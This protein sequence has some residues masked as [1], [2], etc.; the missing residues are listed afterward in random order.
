MSFPPRYAVLIDG[1]FLVRKLQA[2]LRTFPTADHVEYVANAFANHDSVSG[3]DRVRVC[4]YHARPASAVLLNPLSN[5]RLNLTKTDVYLS[6]EHLLESLELRPDFSL[7]LGET[8]VSG[9]KLGE[10]AFKSLLRNPRNTAA[11]DLVPNIEQ[12]GVD[13]RIGLDIARLAL[14][15]SVQAIVVCTADSDLV[16][17]FKFS[18]REGVRVFLSYF[19]HTVKRELKAHADRV[20]DIKLPDPQ[21]VPARVARADVTSKTAFARDV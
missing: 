18:R 20:L 9:W 12:K 16:P 11:G 1:A 7:R 2:Q 17:A 5:R 19:G 15:R 21:A 3:L 6:H 10:S 4:F 8:S 13:L 14:S